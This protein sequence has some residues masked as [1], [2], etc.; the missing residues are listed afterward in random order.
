[1]KLVSLPGSAATFVAGGG[2]DIDTAKLGAELAPGE[3]VRI[4]DD[5]G[6]ELGLAIADPE[7]GKLR[8]IATVADGFPKIDGALL[9]WRLRFTARIVGRGAPLDSAPVELPIVP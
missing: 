3:H 9:G 6:D 2:R 5:Q 8:V 4:A 1:M 7:N